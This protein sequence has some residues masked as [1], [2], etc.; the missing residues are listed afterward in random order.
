MQPAFHLRLTPDQVGQYVLLPG[1]P[2]R[3]PLIAQRLATAGCV[4]C[5]REFTTYTGTLDGVKVSVVSTGI[6]GP[7]AAI[8][9]EELAALGVR[10]A[11]RIGTCGGIADKVRPGDVVI[12]SAACRQEG[13]TREY[14]PLHYP[15]AADYTVLRAL[16]D[17]AAALGVRHH[18]GVIQS[19]DSFYGEHEPERMPVADEL[20]G[21]W[22]AWRRLGVLV[23]E[24]EA[25]ALFVVGASLGV[26][27][28]AVLQTLWNQETG[29]T[30][31]ANQSEAFIDVAVGALRAL[32]KQN[33]ERK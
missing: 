14:A 29:G 15:A 9:L 16:A 7:S 24:M 8:A 21:Y 1:D 27:V 33:E 32:I 3:V 23:S 2:G 11:I 31:A 5:N 10:T 22:N 25:A 18:V 19:K 4:S 13:T 6:G 17:S 20:L 12:A 28:G 26:R 30:D